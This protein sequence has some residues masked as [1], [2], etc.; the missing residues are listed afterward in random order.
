[1]AASLPDRK[2]M[3]IIYKPRKP[4]NLVTTRIMSGAEIKS[5]DRKKKKVIL[6][7]RDDAASLYSNQIKT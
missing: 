4:M 5:Y 7:V 1:L 3:I 6:K 2:L